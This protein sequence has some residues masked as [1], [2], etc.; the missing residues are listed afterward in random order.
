MQAVEAMRQRT[1]LSSRPKHPQES[2]TNAL[3]E[4]GA[5]P[6]LIVALLTCAVHATWPQT[7]CTMHDLAWSPKTPADQALLLARS[8]DPTHE[9]QLDALLAK[10]PD[11][12]SVAL[13]ALAR[14]LTP[15]EHPNFKRSLGHDTTRE[16][17]CAVLAMADPDR[18]E[19]WALDGERSEAEFLDA[20]RA[21][22]FFH[23]DLSRATL[24]DIISALRQDQ[25]LGEDHRLVQRVEAMLAAHSP[26]V[27]ARGALDGTYEMTWTDRI[28]WVADLLAATVETSWLETLAI[29]EVSRARTAFGFAGLLATCAAAGSVHIDLEEAPDAVTRHVELFDML[30]AHDNWE[31]L[32]TS[33]KLQFPLAVADE[34]ITPL[35]VEV[36]LHERLIQASLPSPGIIGLPLSATLDETLQLDAARTLLKDAAMTEKPDEETLC[37]VVRTLCDL[38]GLLADEHPVISKLTPEWRELL[39]PLTTHN[40]R[41][42]ALAASRTLSQM[43]HLSALLAPNPEEPA[44]AMVA[45]LDVPGALDH[46]VK[47][48]CGEGVAALWAARELTELP[49]DDAL[50]LLVQARAACHPMRAPFL[51]QLIEELVEHDE[52]V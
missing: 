11:A 8:E 35:L 14:T 17:T 47:M 24:E 15:W 5:S 28:E 16:S 10:K 29:L 36:A 46:F 3:A 40:Q 50:P 32:A 41:A 38:R 27:Y 7:W 2:I 25:D 19:D 43:Q 52:F 21:L 51:A 18:L 44:D 23:A 20:L 33:L 37:V 48:A 22:L 9:D 1:L 4:P 49:I 13:N 42:I 31:P 26:E 39:D 30:R 34:E 12:A 6:E 45:G